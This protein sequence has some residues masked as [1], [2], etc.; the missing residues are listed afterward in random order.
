MKKEIVIEI[1]KGIKHAKPP[2]F[3]T[4]ILWIFFTSDA[5]LSIKLYFFD[6]FLVCNNMTSDNKEIIDT[7]K[8]VVI[9]IC[10]DY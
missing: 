3:E 5:G 9:K 6:K 8:N 1:K 10:L 2:M 4:G 7:S